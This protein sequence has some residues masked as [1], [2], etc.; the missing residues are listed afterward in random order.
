MVYIRLV[1][2]VIEWRGKA[3]ALERELGVVR[4]EH[5][6]R[7]QKVVAEQHDLGSRQQTLV[8]KLNRALRDSLQENEKVP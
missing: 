7:L 5:E 1:A 8:D 4:E 6:R 3:K 2:E